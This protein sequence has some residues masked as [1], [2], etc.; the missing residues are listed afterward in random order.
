MFFKTSDNG[1]GLLLKS[2]NIDLEDRWCILTTNQMNERTG[3]NWRWFFRSVEQRKH[4]RTEVHLAYD[5]LL[6]K[7][8]IAKTIFYRPEDTKNEEAIL[9]RRKILQEQ[10]N[11]LN[12]VSSPLLPEPLDWF[13]VTN[14]LDNITDKY[15]NSEPVLILDYQPGL[16]ISFKIQKDYFKFNDGFVDTSTIGRILLD[17]LHFLKVLAEHDYACL[18]LTC[19][20][21]LLLNNSKPRFIGIGGICKV[22]DGHLDYDNVNFGRTCKGYAAPEL[23]DPTS[24]W[25][26]AKFATPEQ[27]GAFSL[28]VIL[29]NMAYGV[30]KFSSEMLK[31]GSLYYPNLISENVE[32]KSKKAEKIS[33]LIE[34]LCK[35]NV[36]ERLTDFDEIEE[37]L[38]DIAG[39]IKTIMERKAQERKEREENYRRRQEISRK[40]E[41]ARKAR[42]DRTKIGTVKWYDDSRG[43]GR[44]EC[45]DL[46]YEIYVSRNVLQKYNIGCLQEGMALKF[47]VIESERG[48]YAE[49][50]SILSDN[51]SNTHSSTGYSNNNRT[52][53]SNNDSNSSSGINDRDSNAGRKNFWDRIFGMFS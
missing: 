45:N 17:V 32:I 37:R 29:H 24:D 31:N 38:M 43:Y 39:D 14:T 46:N 8:A 27:I 10:I 3:D 23:N 6:D 36:D 33:R 15:R 13:E 51:T 1:D 12:V 50:I 53:Y 4:V 16:P 2:S 9:K 26:N 7:P 40:R 25:E 20:H 48:P 18:N 52:S 5:N 22:I 11:L 49:N 28:G 44:L 30:E 41:E 19:D 34:D 47:E 35:H 42:Q 21:I